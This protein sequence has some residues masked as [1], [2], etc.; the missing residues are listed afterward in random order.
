MLK[1]E[2]LAKSKRISPKEVFASLKESQKNGSLKKSLMKGKAVYQS[3][4]TYS[5]CIE[6]VHPDGTVVAGLFIKGAF[7]PI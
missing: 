7:V 4:S 2:I 3:S 6:Q 1:Q 5:G